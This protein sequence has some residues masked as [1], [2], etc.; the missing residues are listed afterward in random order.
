MYF[1]CGPKDLSNFTG[2]AENRR[3]IEANDWEY[4]TVEPRDTTIIGARYRFNNRKRCSRY[5]NYQLMFANIDGAWSFQTFNLVSEKVMQTK[6]G[7]TYT[8]QAGT[9][10]YGDYH[11]AGYSRE[12]FEINKQGRVIIELNSDWLSKEQ[13]EDL[14]EYIYSPDV[15]L[16]LN[17]SNTPSPVIVKERSFRP[18][19]YKKLR[20]YKL[21]VEVA[22]FYHRL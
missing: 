17:G 4:Y 7:K 1:M 10:D 21:T 22:Q 12:D 6:G 3:P 19:K 15:Y 8:T 5:D 2:L 9:V 11:V 20:Q 18:D 16:I 13:A 14:E